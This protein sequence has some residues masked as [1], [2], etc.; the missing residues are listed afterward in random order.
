M[1]R[2]KQVDFL[3]HYD[4]L[5]KSDILEFGIFRDGI[6]IGKTNEKT[7]D[8]MLRTSFFRKIRYLI[9]ELLN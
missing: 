7:I 1:F 5:I 2:L 9:K 3:S 6:L 8:T 4:P